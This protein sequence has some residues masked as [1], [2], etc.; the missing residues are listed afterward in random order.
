MRLAVAPD[1]LYGAVRHADGDRAT[2]WTELLTEVAPGL[3]ER[4]GA[5]QITSPVR[6]CVDSPSYVGQRGATAG[7]WSATPATTAT[8][9]NGHGMTD[10][11]RDAEL[12]A[13]ALDSA[14]HGDLPAATALTLYQDV[15]DGALADTYRLTWSSPASRIQTGSSSCRPPSPRPSNV[16]RPNSPP[17]RYPPSG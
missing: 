11:F 7:R 3:G 16:R 2:A 17:D 5:G 9:S 15:R 14:L 13:G 8:R 1:R 4:V 12:L 10:A 6:G